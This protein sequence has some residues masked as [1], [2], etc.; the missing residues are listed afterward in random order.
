MDRQFIT[1]FI[2]CKTIDCFR[3]NICQKLPVCEFFFLLIVEI[4]EHV[5]VLDLDYAEPA[6]FFILVVFVAMPFFL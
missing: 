2:E 4:N 6:F 5:E 1:R 3:I